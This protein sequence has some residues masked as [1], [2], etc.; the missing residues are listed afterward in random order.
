MAR[1]LTGSVYFKGKGVFNEASRVMTGTMRETDGL[2]L[3]LH[4]MLGIGFRPYASGDI[5]KALKAYQRAQYTK[6]KKSGG[7]AP[8]PTGFENYDFDSLPTEEPVMIEPEY[9]YGVDDF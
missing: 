7:S 2:L 4:M 6:N 3:A 8:P 1:L 5:E 9:G